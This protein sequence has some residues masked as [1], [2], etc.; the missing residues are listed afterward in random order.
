MELDP[1][2]NSITLHPSQVP[3][4]SIL[5]CSH[6]VEIKQEIRCTSPPYINF[7]SSA[8]FKNADLFRRNAEVPENSFCLNTSNIPNIMSDFKCFVCGIE[9]D[10]IAKLHVHM[11]L[12]HKGVK[13]IFLNIVHMRLSFD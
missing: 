3:S 8:T 12:R 13:V 9:F 5:D 4:K 1:L 7:N 10:D 2:S 11:S 6:V